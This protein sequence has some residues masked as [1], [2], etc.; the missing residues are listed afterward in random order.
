MNS[1]LQ[2]GSKQC[3][4]ARA[5]AAGACALG[6]LCLAGCNV[7]GAGYFLAYGGP[8]VPAAH[9]LD[10]KQV[11]VVLV[12]DPR[13]RLPSRAVRETIA[14][15]AEKR[16]I[17]AEAVE[18][19]VSTQTALEAASS[20]RPDR[21]TTVAELGR[22]LGADIVIW[23]V[24]ERF[25]L[26]PDGQTH[27]PGGLL[28]VRVIDTRA[29]EVVFPKENPRGFEMEVATRERPGDVP[30]SRSAVMTAERDLA[31]LLGSALGEV[32]LEVERTSSARLGRGGA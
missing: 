20:D 13:N 11:A 1:F 6:M 24:V 12:E 30:T 28:R 9:T 26:S 21:R 17:D 27:Q 3:G 32:F 15:R 14:L 31:E 23:A 7:L 2:C 16:L 19:L 4:L 8:K 22:G 29:D 18:K 5:L 25:G 10:K